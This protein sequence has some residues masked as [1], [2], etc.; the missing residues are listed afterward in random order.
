M[1]DTLAALHVHSQSCRMKSTVEKKTELG[2]TCDASFF[3]QHSVPFWVFCV[4]MQFLGQVQAIQDQVRCDPE[5][6][7]KPCSTLFRMVI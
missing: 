3:S 7:S 2:W 6:V 5:V 4:Q 1:Q